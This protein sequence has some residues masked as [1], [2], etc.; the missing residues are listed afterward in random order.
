MLRVC[1]NEGPKIHIDHTFLD[2]KVDPEIFVRVRIVPDVV[3]NLEWFLSSLNGFTFHYDAYRL[4]LKS[5]ANG[6]IRLFDSVD[7]DYIGP[8][9]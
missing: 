5:E 9:H 7:T 2:L 1:L 8:T 6:I 3:N 4:G